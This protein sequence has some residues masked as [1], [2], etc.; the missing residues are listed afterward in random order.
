MRGR[1]SVGYQKSSYLTTRRLLAQYPSTA[2]HD[3]ALEIAP[4]QPP[5]RLSAGIAV[6]AARTR[7][8]I[9]RLPALERRPAVQHAAIVEYH[10]VA[11]AQ[12]ERVHG[13]GRLDELGVARERVVERGRRV[14]VQ[15]R[16]ERRAVA[17]RGHSGLCAAGSG[18]EGEGRTRVVEVPRGVDVVERDGRRGQTRKV[19][20]VAGAQRFGG[21]EGV[22]E[23]GFAAVH[24]VAQAVQ[25]LETWRAFEVPGS[26]REERVIR[27]FSY[28]PLILEMGL[29]TEGPCVVPGKGWCMRCWGFPRR[30][31]SRSTRRHR[32]SLGSRQS[33]QPSCGPRTLRRS[34]PHWGHCG[35]KVCPCAAAA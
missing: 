10:R 33:T 4:L 7:A 18:V 29:R 26:A 12:L 15:R 24:A 19:L 17:H 27:F 16:L 5:I 3:I 6:A 32:T 14:A 9:R 30:R 35:G 1:D 25:D 2:R 13:R 11:L 28:F 20:R 22:D 23:E 8:R 21:R 31:S 34:S